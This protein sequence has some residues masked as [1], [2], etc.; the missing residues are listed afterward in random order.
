MLQELVWKFGNKWQHISKILT[1]EG[2][3]PRSVDSVRNRHIR[4]KN[5]PKRVGK[6][7]CQLCGEWRSGHTCKA[8]I[9][10]GLQVK[11]T[12]VAMDVLATTT[13]IQP[14]RINKVDM[15]FFSMTDIVDAFSEAVSMDPV[16]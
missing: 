5:G 13:C 12:D 11:L 14:D 8:K 1:K 6:N 9:G 4:L 10:G 3:R 15:V 7:R 2:T 16:G